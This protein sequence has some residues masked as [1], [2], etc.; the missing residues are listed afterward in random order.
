MNI[1]FEQEFLNNIVKL[2]ITDKY[3]DEYL[4]ST[5]HNLLQFTSLKNQLYLLDNN[6]IVNNNK[7]YFIFID[8]V[9]KESLQFALK[10]IILK[11]RKMYKHFLHYYE[12]TYPDLSR[13][14]NLDL[15]LPT[16]EIVKTEK[17]KLQKLP[18]KIQS[19][20]PLYNI[21]QFFDKR[22]DHVMYRPEQSLDEPKSD[23]G[24]FIPDRGSLDDKRSIRSV[25]SEHS[26]RSEKSNDS[27]NSS[28]KSYKINRPSSINSNNT[29]SSTS[30]IKKLKFPKFFVK[31]Q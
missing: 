23:P 13:G 15:Q 6:H 27:S 7:Y 3:F 16:K 31:R 5:R 21:T 11:Q 10:Q 19:H 28:K 17:K 24:L 22:N 26:I 20:H 14:L 18:K 8:N 30:E 25:Q 12:M 2:N 9:K 4:Q 29:N 1:N